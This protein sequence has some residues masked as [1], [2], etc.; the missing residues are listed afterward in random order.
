MADLV[1]ISHHTLVAIILA[2][3]F[4]TTV[5]M[6]IADECK[7]KVPVTLTLLIVPFVWIVIATLRA[8]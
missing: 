3:V 8:M 7:V 5:V 6:A 2:V 4:L 1:H